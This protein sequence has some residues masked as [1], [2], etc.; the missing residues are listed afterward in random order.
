MFKKYLLIIWIIGWTIVAF[1]QIPITLQS[2]NKP[3]NHSP[4]GYVIVGNR[5]GQKI[6][7]TEETDE[8]FNPKN[9][10]ICDQ[11]F[12][13][14]IDTRFENNILYLSYGE[15]PTVY[16]VN[17][18][19]LKVI[20]SGDDFYPDRGFKIHNYHTFNLSNNLVHEIPLNIFE[21]VDSNK[22]YIDWVMALTIMKTKYVLLNC[23]SAS[24]KKISMTIWKTNQFMLKTF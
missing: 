11:N 10:E 15:N 4:D 12:I 24:M 8:K 14:T 5:S 23:Y 13:Y 18:L 19:T 20:P 21:R 6:M 7:I 17:D 16:G 3:S 9:P 1:Q 22:Y 2:L